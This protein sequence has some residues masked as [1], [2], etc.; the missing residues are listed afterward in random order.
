MTKKGATLDGKTLEPPS[1]R[2]YIFE[3]LFM[4]LRAF[5]LLIAMPVSMLAA[6]RVDYLKEIKPILSGA[7]YQCHSETQQK[8]NLRL[9]TAAF[10]LKGGDN[11]PAIVPGKS[12]ES[13]LI[14]AVQGT[15]KD[16]ARM[17][18]K[19]TPLDEEKIALIKQWINEGAHAPSDEKAESV[20][21]WAFVPPPAEV[22]V[23]Q[24]TQ[25]DWPRNAIDSFILARLEKEKIKPAPEADRVTLLRRVSLDLIGLPPTI[26]EVNAFVNDKSPDAYERLV[27]RL[28]ASKHYG[29]R[30]ARH[31]L[32][33]ARYA[34]S[35]GYSIDAPRQIWSYRDWVIKALNRD[36]PF[37]KFTI[38][39]LA[40]DLLPN[41]TLDQ[42]IATGFHRNTMINQE[43]GIDKEQFRV[44]AIIDRVNTT[45]TTWLG[46]TVACSQCHD[47]KF[48]PIAQKEYYQFF[49]FFNNQDEP[50]L[51]IATPAQKMQRDTIRKQ[52]KQAEDGL[53]EYLK[54]LSAEQAA[55]EKSL[56]PEEVAKLKPEV[57]TILETPPDKRNSK[58]Q[59]ALLDHIR[60]DDPIYK[61]RKS[62]VTEL[63]KKVPKFQTTMVLRRTQNAS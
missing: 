38:E 7:C 32:D 51:E 23:P 5:F 35:S 43:G 42:K 14:K 48:D 24:V 50:D 20:L 29:E 49:A 21:H 28:L 36:L 63:E 8:H 31:W 53:K 46:L 26:E 4:N 39:Q 62:K 30:W 15:A 60:K 25:K 6:E 13:L 58:Q 55:W 59:Q 61:Q 12:E 52:I 3:S 19:K 56:T 22:P 1:I 16:L 44:E 2:D 18:Y 34:D 47:H 40:G 27:E 17:P 54:T 41:A 45:A 57:T 9:D 37:D 11:G 10:A 33:A